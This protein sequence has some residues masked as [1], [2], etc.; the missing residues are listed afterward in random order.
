M[1]DGSSGQGTGRVAGMGTEVQA[2]CGTPASP[3]PPGL[4]ALICQR[5]MESEVLPWED[6]AG[7]AL[8]GPQ[9]CLTTWQGRSLGDKWLICIGLLRSHP[10]AS[11]DF[12]SSSHHPSGCQG[13][14]SNGWNRPPGYFIKIYLFLQER[15]SE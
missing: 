15:E 14:P 7:K 6:R 1:T 5:R 4:G 11:N 10:A 8:R 3:C 13:L 12:I 9:T 2:S